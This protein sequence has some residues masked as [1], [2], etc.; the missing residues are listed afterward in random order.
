MNFKYLIADARMMNYKMLTSTNKMR[1]IFAVNTTRNVEY[2]ESVKPAFGIYPECK[3]IIS[4]HIL[5]IYGLRIFNISGGGNGLH[6][7]I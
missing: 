5:R 1:T 6:I 7:E 2:P 3:I 4:V